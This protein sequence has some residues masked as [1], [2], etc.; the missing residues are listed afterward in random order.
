MH[1][2]INSLS[3]IK[4]KYK[5]ATLIAKLKEHRKNH[6]EEYKIAV[7]EYRRAVLEQVHKMLHVAETQDFTVFSERVTLQ[8]PVN[9]EEGYSKLIAVFEH[10]TDSVIELEFD[11][12]TKLLTDTWDWAVSAKMTNMLYS[13]SASR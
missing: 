10:M 2:M 5:R 12:A 13:T 1:H 6:V 4:G 11:E 8:A 9:V 3:N 7:V